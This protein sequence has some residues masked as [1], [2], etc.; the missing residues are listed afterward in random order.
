MKSTIKYILVF[1]IVVSIISYGDVVWL[2]HRSFLRYFL[3][4]TLEIGIFL[5]G[6]L[7]GYIIPKEKK[8]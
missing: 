4:T 8:E 1:F 6:I 3:A 7:I 2:G 5:C